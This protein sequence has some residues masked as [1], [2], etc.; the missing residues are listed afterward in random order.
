MSRILVTG[1]A[2]AI[3]NSLCRVLVAEGHEVTVLD[4]LSSGHA[5]F[6]PPEVRF[7]EASLLD[8]EALDSAFA[9][10]PQ[11]V[12]HLAALFANQNSVE[13]PEADLE[14]NGQGML[15]ILEASSRVG[16]QKLVYTSS[17]CIYGNRELMREEDGAGNLDTP[18]AVTKYLGELY[19]QYWVQ[20]MGLNIAIARLFNCYGP[21]ELPGPYRN[22]TTN[23]FARA[24]RGEALTIT[25]DGSE[26]RD[27]TFV[28]DTVEGLRLLLFGPTQ[29]GEVFN[30]A[31][32]EPTPILTLA[33]EINRLTAN[34]APIEF[35]SRRSWDHV[36]SRVGVIDRIRD[37]LGYEPRYSL[38]DGLKRTCEWMRKQVGQDSPEA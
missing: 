37:R 14:A 17:S 38:A 8:R 32:G 9:P 21:Y 34:P 10:A 30:I 19:S 35:R 22:V 2:G 24:L 7:L 28:E 25:G 31:T 23:F 1:G 12:V 3:G 16:V 27:F 11:Y 5:E 36:R 15:R 20:Q 33:E 29:P 13:H 26:T 6:L 18:Y 4:D